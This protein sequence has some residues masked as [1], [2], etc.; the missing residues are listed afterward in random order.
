M[1]ST[2]RTIASVST[3]SNS[4]PQSDLDW[5]TRRKPRPTPR[6]EYA[7]MREYVM[8]LSQSPNGGS[9]G[10]FGGGVAL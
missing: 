6:R 10:P 8:V 3:Q 5:N 1:A 2:K 7:F 9:F 4:R